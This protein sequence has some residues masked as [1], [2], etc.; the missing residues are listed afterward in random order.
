MRGLRAAQCCRWCTY[1]PH[2]NI[3]KFDTLGAGVP[4]AVEKLSDNSLSKFIVGSS[5]LVNP[6]I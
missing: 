6:P 1:S 3:I 4:E 2:G 5:E